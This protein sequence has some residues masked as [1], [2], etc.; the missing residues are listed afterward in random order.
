MIVKKLILLFLYLALPIVVL[1]QLRV[2]RSISTQYQFNGL[3]IN[4]A[5]SAG[6]KQG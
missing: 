1:A 2:Q 5:F 6:E 3:A 4:P